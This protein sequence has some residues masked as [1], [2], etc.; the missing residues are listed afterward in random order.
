M[1]LG[2]PGKTSLSLPPQT[3]GDGFDPGGDTKICCGGLYSIVPKTF[4]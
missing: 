4:L 3:E 2:R 1:C